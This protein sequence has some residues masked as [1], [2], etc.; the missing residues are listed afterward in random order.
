MTS[1]NWGQTTFSPNLYLAQWGSG[2][3]KRGLSPISRRIQWLD[4]CTLLPEK[5]ESL[6]DK[7][8]TGSLSNARDDGSLLETC[9]LEPGTIAA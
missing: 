1:N 5:E 7:V 8:L 9:Y 4:G 3:G 2:K 6:R